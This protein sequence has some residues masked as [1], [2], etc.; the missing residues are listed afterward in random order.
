MA[1]C[2]RQGTH[3]RSHNALAL[4]LFGCG[5]RD[6]PCAGNKVGAKSCALRNHM[7]FAALAPWKKDKAGIRQPLAE[8]PLFWTTLGQSRATKWACRRSSRTRHASATSLLWRRIPQQAQQWPAR[9]MLLSTMGGVTNDGGFNGGEFCRPSDARR[10]Q[11]VASGC[12]RRLPRP[13][14][15]KAAKLGTNHGRDARRSAS[16]L[17][18]CATVSESVDQPSTLPS[19]MGSPCPS[20]SSDLPFHRF[21]HEAY[22]VVSRCVCDSRARG[23]CQAV[24]QCAHQAY[25]SCATGCFS[26]RDADSG[27]IPPK[28]WV[29]HTNTHVC[30]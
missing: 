7:L 9:C 14:E 26:F 23:C 12:K 1:F 30:F 11:V 13:G 15:H 3:D 28:S 18:Q 4:N 16:S 19:P 17:P 5:G 8:R 10:N 27:A 22:D 25:G 24:S 29:M 2:S 21:R 6:E 20:A